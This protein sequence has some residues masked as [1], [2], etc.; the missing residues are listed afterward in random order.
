[1]DSLG[2]R[3]GPRDLDRTPPGVTA[4]AFCAREVVPNKEG[5]R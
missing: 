1:M 2:F 4:C 5:I 3:I